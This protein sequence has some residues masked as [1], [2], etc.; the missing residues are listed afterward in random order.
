MGKIMVASFLTQYIVTLAPA[1][2]LA[3]CWP[4]AACRYR[5]HSAS[6]CFLLLLRLLS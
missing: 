4:W 5:P 6:P 3:G 1:V 2:L